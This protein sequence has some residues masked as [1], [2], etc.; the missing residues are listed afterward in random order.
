MRSE[1][2]L[3]RKLVSSIAG[4]VTVVLLVNFGIAMLIERFFPVPTAADAP[5]RWTV[6]GAGMVMIAL[7][8]LAICLY[9]QKK[10]SN[11]KKLLADKHQQ[12]DTE[13]TLRSKVEEELRQS[14]EGLEQQLEERI[15]HSS[16]IEQTEDN[17]LITD[18]HRTILYINPA[19]ERSCGYVCE[20]LKNKPLRCLRSDQHDQGFYRTMKEVLDRGEVWMGVIFNKG[21]NGVDFEIEG[22]ISPIRESSGAIS[23]WVAVGRNMNRFRK[24]EQE[25]QRVQKMD[26][27]GTLAGGI[28]HDFNNVLTAVM[29]LI[30]L[31]TLDSESGNRTRKRMHQA[32]SACTRARDL[33]KQILTFSRQGEQRR[34]PLRLGPV[35]EDALQ[36]LR[37]TLPTT[38]TIEP[39]LAAAD[40]LILGDSTQIHQILVNL[41]TN[42]AHAMRRLG[43]ILRVDLQEVSI[44][45]QNLFE[46]PDLQPGSYLCLKVTDTG[47]GMDQRVRERIFE[48]FFTTK[49]PGEGAGVGLS[50]VHGIVRSH[51]G[52]IL[53]RSEPGKGTSF[54]LF[55]PKIEGNEELPDKHH[56][57]PPAGTGRI[58]LVDDEAL[59]VGVASEMLQFLGYEVV[60]VQKSLE[61]LELFRQQPDGFQLVITDLTMPGITGME[62]ATELLLIRQDIPIILCSGFSDQGVRA[63]ASAIGVRKIIAKP[64]ILQDLASSVREVLDHQGAP[65]GHER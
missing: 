43:G 33:V 22:T 58:L 7:T 18:K 38:I 8:S 36:M 2:S 40:A 3:S 64:F 60:A 34:K 27:L 1:K 24:L 50:V 32:L 48:P 21:K 51:G 11:T 59:V 62:L 15:L 10:L 9:F 54:H 20:E 47:E 6:I 16:V 23:H 45:D 39:D 52:T 31:Q 41:C 57:S 13:H 5:D 30:E 49:K 4:I 17:V 25:L 26:A 42:A 14:L 28:A 29:G 56:D 63:K 61:A 46:P 12:L 19:F 65:P 35:I 53:V 55:F 44:D 37:A